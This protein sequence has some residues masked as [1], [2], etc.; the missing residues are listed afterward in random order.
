LRIRPEHSKYYIKDQS[1]SSKPKERASQTHKNGT[2][3]MI[4]W[5]RITSQEMSKIWLI[6]RVW[7]RIRQPLETSITLL[8]WLIN[9]QPSTIFS[10]EVSSSRSQVKEYHQ[11]KQCKISTNSKTNTLAEILNT[12]KILITRQ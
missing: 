7:P 9:S 3:R 1:P 5:N 10:R 8:K 2:F 4:W 11:V 6:N 12:R